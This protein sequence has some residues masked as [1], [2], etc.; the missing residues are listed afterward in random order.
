VKDPGGNIDFEDDCCTIA[1]DGAGWGETFEGQTSSWK[2]AELLDIMTEDAE[3]EDNA[4]D[5]FDAP[6]E[7]WKYVDPGEILSQF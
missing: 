6:K 2:N 3:G 1:G 7:K 5:A 4:Y